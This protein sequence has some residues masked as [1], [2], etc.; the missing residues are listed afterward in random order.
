MDID[1]ETG[2]IQFTPMRTPYNYDRDAVSR[3]TGLRC[4]DPSLTQQNTKD[5]TDINVIMDRYMQ[6][7][8]IPQ[9]ARLPS[10]GDFDGV[11]DYHTAM[12]AIRSSEEA[13]MA[14]PATIRDRF[15]NDPQQLLEFMSHDSN[16]AE[17]YKLGLVQTPPDAPSVPVDKPA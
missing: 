7:G 10:Y 8:M 11:T 6:T 16:H 1:K 9:G 2:E 5:E 4:E 3:A 15:D 13:F 14:L 17:A 12:N